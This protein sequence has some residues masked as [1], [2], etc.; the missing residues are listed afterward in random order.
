MVETCLTPA[1]PNALEPLLDEPL[2]GTFNHPT[3]QRQPQ[4][5]VRG[6]IQVVA[7]LIQIGIHLA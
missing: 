1:H 2:A 4:H 5:L 7:M 3:A 6:I